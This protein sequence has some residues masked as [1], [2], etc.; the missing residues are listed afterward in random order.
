MSYLQYLKELS[1]HRLAYLNLLNTSPSPTSPA[2]QKT[3]QMVKTHFTHGTVMVNGG[4]DFATAEA[5]VQ[6]HPND[7]VSFGRPFIANPDFPAKLKA[8][9]PLKVADPST[10]YTPGEKGYTDY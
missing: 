5:H 7:V 6:A 3:L 9:L 2:F 1:K 8:G 4:Y 10:F